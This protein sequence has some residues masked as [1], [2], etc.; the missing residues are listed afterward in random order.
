[1]SNQTLCMLFM[2]IKKSRNHT[3]KFLQRWQITD[4]SDSYMYLG[5]E[6]LKLIKQ[7]NATQISNSSDFLDCVCS[8]VL[9]TNNNMVDVLEFHWPGKWHFNTITLLSYTKGRGPFL[10][11]PRNFSNGLVTRLNAD[12][13][14]SRGHFMHNGQR[15]FSFLLLF[16][17]HL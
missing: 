11:S 3:N 4:F 14:L 13:S 8:Q 9:L 16:F 15:F 1:M 6:C 7:W 5:W 17:R 10:E 12:P 2:A